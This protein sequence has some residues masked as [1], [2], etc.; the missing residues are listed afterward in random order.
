MKCPKRPEGGDR[1]PGTGVSDLMSHPVGVGTQPK[2]STNE[3][4]APLTAESSLQP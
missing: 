4:S 3:Q 2:S 1:P